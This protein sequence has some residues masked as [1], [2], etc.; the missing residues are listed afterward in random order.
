[1]PATANITG[2]GANSSISVDFIRCKPS[3]VPQPGKIIEL[4]DRRGFNGTAARVI[5]KKGLPFTTEGIADVADDTAAYQLIGK[6]MLLQG[7]T[8]TYTNDHNRTYLMT[9]LRV[10]PTGQ[11]AIRTAVGGVGTNST[12]LVVVQLD[13]QELFVGP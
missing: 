8:V 13:M 5:G 2:T 9:L 7:E 12:L 4:I 11:R 6:L 3:A 10:T 1:M